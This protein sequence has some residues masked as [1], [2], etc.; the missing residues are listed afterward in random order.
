LSPPSTCTRREAR[1]DTHSESSGPRIESDVNVVGEVRR[2]R[3]RRRRLL[4]DPLHPG[5]EFLVGLEGDE[6]RPIPRDD[7]DAAGA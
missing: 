5:V 4:L 1:D 3:K 6:V 7:L 2:S